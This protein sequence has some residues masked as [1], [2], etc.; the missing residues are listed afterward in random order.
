MSLETCD[1][2][3]FKIIEKA[4]SHLL[5]AT[6]IDM[7]PKEMEVL[8]SFLFR[9]WQM[10][11]LDRYENAAELKE[12]SQ[13]DISNLYEI[14]KT[15]YAKVLP[16]NEHD[17]YNAIQEVA[18]WFVGKKY[19]MLLCKERSDYT[20]FNF[21]CGDSPDYQRAA[22]YNFKACLDNRG[23]CLEIKYDEAMDAFEIWMRIDKE[24]FMF[25]LF[26]CKDFIIEVE[27][28]KE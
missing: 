18:E 27:S 17:Y 10:G 23:K 16:Y 25:Y 1:D 7:A 9:C 19:C 21:K 22:H 15:G 11:W 5:D 2:N 8:D 13:I 24:V 6:N 4:K 26:E 20:V 12:G 28:K 3:R 14:N